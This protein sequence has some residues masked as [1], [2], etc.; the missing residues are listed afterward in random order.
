MHLP[1]HIAIIPDGN[2]RWAKKEGLPSFLGHTKGAK[3][4]ERVLKTA[5]DMNI[6]AVTVWGSSVSNVT[7]RPQKEVAFLF[8]VF[9]KQFAKLAK[10]KDLKK[11]GVRVRIFGRW[12]ELFP[13]GTKKPMREVVENT[14]DNAKH[15]LTFLMAYSGT[16]EMLKAIKEM[17][18][19][20]AVDE[21]TIKNHL[22]TKELP[23]V[24]LVVRT[25]GEPHWSAGFMMWDVAEAML[26]FTETLWPDLS[27]EEFTQAIKRYS[28]TQRRFGK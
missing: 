9:K 1:K 14:K 4:M 11:R 8:D 21:R 23:P 15:H 13:E 10:S 27:S 20:S 18:R 16:D 28:D 24:D 26:Y 25:G 7:K 3:A 12:E 22:W 17:P 5:L 6:P 2:R 19:G